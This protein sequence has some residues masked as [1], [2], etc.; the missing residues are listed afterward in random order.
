MLDYFLHPA[1]YLGFFLFIAATGCGMPIPEE[2][3]IVIAGVLCSQHQLQWY[4]AFPA[5][6]L[7]AVVGDSFMYA[8]GHRWGHSIFTLHPRFAKLFATENE[9][10]FQKAVEAHALKVMLVARFLVGIRAPVYLMTGVVRLPFRR[11]LLYDI[12]SASL[13]VGAV[14]GLSYLF[15]DQ[16]TQW[17]RHA[18][19][20]ATLVVLLIL[21]AIVAILY[22]RHKDQVLA[23]IFD[24]DVP[25]AEN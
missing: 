1:G 20:R 6:L 2:A 14:F 16:V 21:I 25:P 8:I 9:Q 22:Y 17:V 10:Q 18:E 23:M 5:C 24:R 7:G 4:Y 13:V 15:G 11:F 12:I 3:A 19:I